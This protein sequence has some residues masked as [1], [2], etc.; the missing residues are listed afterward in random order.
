MFSFRWLC[1]LW[2][3]QPE[4]FF[5]DLAFEVGQPQAAVEALRQAVR[6]NPSDEAS[7]RALAK[8]L[9][10]EFQTPEAI[11]LFWRAFDKA[12]D[13]EGQTN[14][15]VALSNLYLRSNQFEKLIERL[16]MRSRETSPRRIFVSRLATMLC[17]DPRIS[18]GF[19]AFHM[20]SLIL[21]I[22]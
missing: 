17:V 1:W 14:I 5:A 10:D 20:I 21:F 3:L 6:V 15:V 11:E 4:Q 22:F 7:L 9:A 12:P 2:S 8:T 13:L 19:L 16:E 18:Y